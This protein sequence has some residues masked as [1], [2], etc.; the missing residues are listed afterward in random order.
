MNRLRRGP[1]SIGCLILSVDLLL[2]SGCADNHTYTGQLFEERLPVADIQ[3]TS[4]RGDPFDLADLRGKTVLVFFGY[5]CCPDVCPM[6]LLEVGDALSGIEESSPRIAES[7][8]AVFVT[9][10]PERDSVERMA[11]YVTALHP[12]I[13]GVVVDPEQLEA[14][15][16][17]FGVYAQKSEASASS[18]AGYLV[19]HTAAIYVIDKEGNLAALFSHDTPGAAIA[20]D[21]QALLRR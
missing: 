5:T 16:S 1:S 3:G 7:V 11:Q 13:T 6:T 17:S 20:A 4:H 21:I 18:D 12:A 15:K 14:I 19:D 2:L 9:V 8:A 10:D